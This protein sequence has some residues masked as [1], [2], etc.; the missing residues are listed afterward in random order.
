MTG[1][2]IVVQQLAYYWIIC[3]YKL[4]LQEYNHRRRKLRDYCGWAVA[5]LQAKAHEAD[6]GLQ[7]L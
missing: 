1:Y 7:I 5:G 2:K 3:Y 4:Q 6:Q